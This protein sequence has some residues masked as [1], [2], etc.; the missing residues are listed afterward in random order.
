MS[1]EFI[2]PISYSQHESYLS[3]LPS[4]E[5]KIEDN[6][7]YCRKPNS[8]WFTTNDAVLQEGTNIKLLGSKA[9]EID[10]AGVKVYPE[11]YEAVARSNLLVVDALLR[12]KR[13]KLV[14]YY[15]GQIEQKEVTDILSAHFDRDKMPDIV[16]QVDQIFQRTIRGTPIRSNNFDFQFEV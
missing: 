1:T 2:N 10:H 9:F 5:W 6:T 7:L 12:K 8:A 3:I 16:V 15:Y 11:I 13:D 4:I 14:L